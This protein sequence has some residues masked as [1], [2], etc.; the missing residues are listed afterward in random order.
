MFFPLAVVSL[1]ADVGAVC[2]PLQYRVWQFQ[3]YNMEHI[4]R[5]IGVAAQQGVNRI[6]LSHN[7]VM[8]SEEILS[9]PQ[10]VKD[11]N[12]A[13]EWAHAKGIKVDIWTH[14]LNG[15]PKE[16]LKDGKANLDDP[17]L[18]EWLRGKYARVFELCPNVDGLVLTM[19]ETA[20][21]I[22]HEKSVTSSI[23]PEKRVAKLIEDIASVCKGFRK[24]LFVRTFSYEPAELKYI[25][26]GLKQS[27]ADIIVMT[28]CQ[29]HDWTPF[30]P[31]NPA[32]GSIGDHPQIVEFDLGYEFLGLSRIPYIDLDYLAGRLKHDISKGV[33]G[34]VLRIERLEWRATDTPNWATVE[35]FTRML[36]DPCLDQRKAFREWLEARY[37][38]QVAPFLESAFG[39]TFEIVNKSY[40]ALGGWITR[41]SILPDYAYATSSLN[42]RATSKWDPEQEP[43]KQ[44]LLNPTEETIRKI[45]REKEKAIELARLSLADVDSVKARMKSRDYDELR[46]LFERELAMATVW[47]AHYELYFTIR[48]YE[49][50]PTEAAAGRIRELSKTL[51]ALRDKRRPELV[52]LAASYG[53]PNN[54][55]NVQAINAMLKKAE[56][57]IGS[58]P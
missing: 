6:Q 37:G 31:H 27:K 52:A 18:W 44:E 51:E 42:N 55:A 34:G 22:Y 53:N 56:E 47:K 19:Q 41:H 13:T 9:R 32:I 1:S 35:L 45:S 36:N 2:R 12:S 15:V 50:K 14:E 58:K 21:S 43:V 40:F 8:D 38:R 26:D 29:P 10:L 4:K 54:Q 5:L 24:D 49:R 25:C 33:A 48:L 30:Y 7:I 3:D 11:I 23:S 16:L 17:K 57:A 28:K 20:M 46:T 39:R